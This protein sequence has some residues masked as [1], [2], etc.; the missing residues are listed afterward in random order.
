MESLR[1]I[2]TK[3]LPFA[4]YCVDMCVTR[5]TNRNVSQHGTSMRRKPRN[6]RMALTSCC[7]CM[8]KRSLTWEH[9]CGLRTYLELVKLDTPPVV[10]K[11]LTMDTFSRVWG[12]TWILLCVLLCK[13][14]LWPATI[15]G[16]KNCLQMQSNVISEASERPFIETHYSFHALA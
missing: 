8:C 6:R 13:K 16:N 5:D 2:S 14:W 15:F 9:F 4:N 1:L 7:V 10:Q 12:H 3:A 11:F